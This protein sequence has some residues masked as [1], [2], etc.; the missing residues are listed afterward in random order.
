M[1]HLILCERTLRTPSH[2]L[3]H[4]V[5]STKHPRPEDFVVRSPPNAQIGRPGPPLRVCRIWLRARGDTAGRAVRDE[6][7]VGS[8]V[9]DQREE[10]GG[11][12]GE[13]A[14][15]GEGLQRGEGIGEE[16]PGRSVEASVVV[17]TEDGGW[18]AAAAN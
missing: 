2:G 18:A 15:C 3:E 8:D 11:V 17:G 10:V 13:D 6:I 1:R 7:G 14:G 4:L 9:R 16:A 12:V 5:R